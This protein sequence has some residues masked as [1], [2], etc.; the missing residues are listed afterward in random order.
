MKKLLILTTL[1]M[2]TLSSASG[3]RVWNWFHRGDQCDS[4]MTSAGCGGSTPIYSGA[5]SGSVIVP[6]VPGSTSGR[7]ILPGPGVEVLPNG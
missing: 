5:P 6:S 4:C 2:L 7:G 3:C 1:A